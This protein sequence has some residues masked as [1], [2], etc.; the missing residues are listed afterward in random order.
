MRNIELLSP[1]GDKNSLTSAIESGADAVYLGLSKFN[2]RAKADNFDIDDM[3]DICRRAHLQGVKVYVT[4]NTLLLDSEISEIVQMVGKAMS[5]GVDAFIVQDLGL[6]YA[7]KSVYPDVVLHGSTQLGVHNARGCKIAKRLGL[8][9][10]VLSRETRIQDIIDIRNNVDIELEYF[11]QG[12]L[13]VAFS[14]NCYIS[15]IKNNASG[16]RGACKQLCRLPYKLSDSTKSLSGYAISPADICMLPMLQQLI[17]AG[18]TSFKIEGRLR[19]SGYVA[20]ATKVYRQALDNIAVNNQSDISEMQDN[21]KRVFAR[22]EYVQ[23][24]L[25]SDNIINVE[26]NSHMGVHIGQV[27]SCKRFKDMYAIEISSDKLLQQGD[28]LKFVSK[29]TISMGVGNVRLNGNNQ[30]VFGNRYIDIGS[31][32]YLTRDIAFEN[33][34]IKNTKKTKLSLHFVALVGKRSCLKIISDS[35]QVEVYGDIVEQSINKQLSRESVLSALGKLD[36]DIFEISDIAIDMSQVY[37][38]LSALN[39]LRRRAIAQLENKLIDINKVEP[40][41]MPTLTTTTCRY[42]SIAIVDEHANIDQLK[43]Y[44]A[45][46]LSPTK[47]DIETVDNFLKKY[48]RKL[49]NK[50]ILNLPIIARVQDQKII[51]Q[52]VDRFKSN[53]EFVANNIY[54]LDYINQGAVVLAG[55]GL[56]VSNNYSKTILSHLGTIEVMSSVEKWCPTLPNSYK[57]VKGKLV[58]M[59]FCHC[60][61]K[62]LH[63]ST[64]QDCKHSQLYLSSHASRMAIRR[65]QISDCYFELVDDKSFDLDGKHKI[66]DLRI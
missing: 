23:G 1:A 48:K 9:R 15:S 64:C 10:V 16:N 44:D 28:G 14:G 41:P 34:V 36:K 43:S 54:A 27:V 51:D 63:N 50:L 4:L 18:I 11:V 33:A 57:F 29:D 6:I 40:N 24:Y 37:M 46:V 65:Y 25:Q 12:A 62:T 35:I 61:V 22:G 32:V 21:L 19:H 55:M 42:Q 17:D 58:L 60:P 52:I 5:A 2:A 3:P 13:C 7:L 30:I 26:T 49:T 66:I 8:S 56:N 38:P 31:K 39:E 47:Y 20:V 45:L 59:T 53:I